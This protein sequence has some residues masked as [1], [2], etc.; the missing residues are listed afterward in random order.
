MIPFYY[1]LAVAACA[2]YVGYRVGTHV[3][4]FAGV[5]KAA[6]VFHALL[7]GASPTTPTKES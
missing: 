1:F 7:Y 2:G 4:Y 3:G 5:V 6:T